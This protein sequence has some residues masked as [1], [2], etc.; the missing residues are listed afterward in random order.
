MSVVKSKQFFYY[1]SWFEKDIASIEDLLY[2]DM[3]TPVLKSFD[4]R[5]LEY[6]IS[7]KDRR[8]YNFLM[9]CIVEKGLLED[10]TYHLRL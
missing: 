4:D 7:C 6:G 1:D 10:A 5:I 3:P 9:K 8:K 2:K